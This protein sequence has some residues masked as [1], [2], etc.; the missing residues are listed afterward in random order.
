MYVSIKTETESI[1]FQAWSL[2]GH[3][4]MFKGRL[5]N[6]LSFHS[7]TR[8]LRDQIA[9]KKKGIQSRSVKRS[10]R[11]KR[12]IDNRF[13]F[14]IEA[15]IQNCGHASLCGKGLDQIVISLI[16]VSRNRL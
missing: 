10:D 11:V 6:W 2:A 7:L 1:I 9:I 8:P 5:A 14:E 13:S 15:C 4:F 12:R 16:L 3:R